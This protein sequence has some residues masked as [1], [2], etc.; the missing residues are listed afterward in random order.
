MKSELFNDG[1]VACGAQRIGAEICLVVAEVP[2][3]PALGV[4]LVMP[5][6]PVGPCAMRLGRDQ[7]R[8]TALSID[9]LNLL[10]GVDPVIEL[11]PTRVGETGPVGPA[12]RMEDI[13][14]PINELDVG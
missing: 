8:R 2:N 12:S 4:E 11:D 7:N 6:T 10:D 5:G 3:V 9:C 14:V 1:A 13:P